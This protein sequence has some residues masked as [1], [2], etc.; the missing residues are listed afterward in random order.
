MMAVLDL[1]ESKVGSGKG[2]P[3]K[4]L[5]HRQARGELLVGAVR[6]SGD[7]NFDY[8]VGLVGDVSAQN[9]LKVSQ[10]S[11]HGNTEGLVLTYWCAA[12]SANYTPTPGEV[13]IARTK[14]GEY[15]G[16]VFQGESTKGEVWVHY[17]SNGGLAQPDLVFVSPCRVD[18]SLGTLT[19]DMR[20]HT[21]PDYDDDALDTL[22]CGMAN[23]EVTWSELVDLVLSED[24][25]HPLLLK[26]SRRCPTLVDAD[27]LDLLT[28]KVVSDDPL[29]LER[30]RNS[31]LEFIGD[32]SGSA[33]QA[34]YNT[35]CERMGEVKS[36]KGRKEAMAHFATMCAS[37]VA[38][39]V[40]YGIARRAFDNH[41]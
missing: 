9:K 3:A 20:D 1:L 14:D 37:R 5:A 31:C 23:Y 25:E 12:R 10:L 26:L 8:R 19:H 32:L 28:G 7:A 30:D 39:Q 38:T 16:A 40:L 2:S 6:L 11:T 22:A 27:V 29:E 15:R 33:L 4:L 34:T 18:D 24:N 21:F 35:A 36:A 17:G 41:G 13:V